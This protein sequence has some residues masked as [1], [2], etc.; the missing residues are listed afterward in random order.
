MSDTVQS[1]LIQPITDIYAKFDDYSKAY[2]TFELCIE[3][4]GL[5]TAPMTKNTSNTYEGKNADGTVVV[6]YDPTN[7][8]YG[9]TSCQSEAAALNTKY[10]AFNGALTTFKT[11]NVPNVTSRVDASFNNPTEFQQYYRDMQTSRSNLDMKLEQLY[12]IQ[13][14]LPSMSDRSVDSVIL[15]SILWIVLASALIYYIFIGNLFNTFPIL[16]PQSADL[17]S[18]NLGSNFRRTI[19]DAN[20]GTGTSGFMSFVPSFL[21]KTSS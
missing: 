10:T 9:S 1:N 12:K 5:T 13:N 21:K 2:N 6:T 20:V 14:S 17:R 7:K 4:Q 19:G 16:S 15:A 11:V 18:S 8:T 3:R